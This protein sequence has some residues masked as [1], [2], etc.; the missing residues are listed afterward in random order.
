MARAKAAPPPVTPERLREVLGSYRYSF[1]NERDL[2]DG[3]AQALFQRGI[4]F[5]RGVQ[6]APK[7][8]VADFLVE[9]TAVAVVLDRSPAEVL[10]ELAPWKR[11]SA[12]LLVLRRGTPQEL[13]RKVGGKPVH[14]VNVGG[15]S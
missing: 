15:V 7:G 13:P 5:D 12:V 9:G 3:I 8:A 6:V 4:R 2:Q 14:V 10:G 11:A 1:A